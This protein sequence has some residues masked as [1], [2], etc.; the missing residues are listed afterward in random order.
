MSDDFQTFEEFWPYYVGEHLKPLTR[1]MHFAGTAAMFAC[2]TAF[3]AT[4]RPRWLLAAAVAG[5]GPAWTSHFFI[6]GNRPATFRHPL[7]SLLA[8]FRMFGRMV[9]GTMDAEVERVRA[10]RKADARVD[11]SVAAREDRDV[12]AMN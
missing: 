9:A 8:D 1:R 6:E 2:V 4:R 11:G 7:W 10:A 5:Y 12:R 3:V